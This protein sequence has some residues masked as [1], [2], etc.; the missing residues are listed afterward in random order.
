MVVAGVKLRLICVQVITL[1]PGLGVRV[2]SMR[3]GGAQLCRNCA[4]QA[5]M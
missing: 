4:E 2:L 1:R 5:W 3:L